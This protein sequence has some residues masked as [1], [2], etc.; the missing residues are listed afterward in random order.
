MLE[1]A[2]GIRQSHG[3]L[4]T[5]L[6]W[7]ITFVFTV[8]YFVRIAVVRKPRKYIFSFY[9]II[10]FLSIL[11]TYLSLILIG[12]HSL[13]AEYCKKCGAKLNP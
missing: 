6:E 4:L 12:S 1:S 11:P 7:I 2:P 13:D 5:I 9:G 10:D 8:E 3:E